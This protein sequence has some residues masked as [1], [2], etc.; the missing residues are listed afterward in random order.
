MDLKKKVGELLSMNSERPGVIHIF[1]GEKV[2]HLN[3]YKVTIGR[4]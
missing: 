2:F 4:D 1:E 3:L